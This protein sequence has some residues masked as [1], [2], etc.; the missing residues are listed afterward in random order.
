MLKLDITEKVGCP[1]TCLNPI[2][3]MSKASG[4]TLLYL[5]MQQANKAIIQEGHIIPKMEDI[6]TE[7]HSKVFL[8]NQPYWRL[9]LNKVKS[10]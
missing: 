2:V 4:K 1:T 10:K 7:L 5:D 9:P 6:L 8:K 3:V